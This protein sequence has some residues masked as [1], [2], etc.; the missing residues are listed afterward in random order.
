MSARFP[1]LV[2]LLATTLGGCISDDAAPVNAPEPTGP[3]PRAAGP[4]EVSFGEVRWHPQQP[5]RMDALRIE[6]EV[7]TDHPWPGL[8]CRVWKVQDD[9]LEGGAIYGV[10]LTQRSG[11]TFACDIPGD[12]PAD[13]ILAYVLAFNN[14]T[15]T[16]SEDIRIKIAEDSPARLQPAFTET[17]VERL[18]EGRD[19]RLTASLQPPDPT[20]PATQTK[21]V[22]TYC[23]LPPSRN[24]ACG[25]V[26]LDHQN[27]RYAGTLDVAAP[28][29]EMNDM[30]PGR[31]PP[32][33]EL[34]IF[35]Y[36][37][38]VDGGFTAT[39]STTHR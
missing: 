3:D 25:S 13:H 11:N 23:I 12:H 5:G 18:R 24:L 20:T 26:N 2:L 7:I 19:V 22:A 30:R 16:R 14:V 6:V 15:W 17:G 28:L 32:P 21:V 4:Q 8:S 38:Y 37:V 31:A 27:T 10:P 29:T 39:G 35:Y 33:Y 9:P 1:L 36:A 34:V